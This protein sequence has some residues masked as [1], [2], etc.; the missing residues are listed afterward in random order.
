MKT[1]PIILFVYNRPWHTRQ[2]VEAL[3]KNKLADQSDLIIYADGAKNREAVPAVEEVRAYLKTITGFK[4]ISIIEQNENRGLANSIIE[5]VTSVVNQ[6]GRVIVVEDDLVTSSWFLGYMN[7]GLDIFQNRD[8]IFS[9]TGFNYPKHT[10]DI[11]SWYIED[12]Y[13]SYRCMSWTWGTWRDRWDKVD[14]DVKDFQILEKSKEKI[15]AFNRGGED[16]FPMLKSQMENKIDSWAIRFCYA[17]HI[18]KSYCV[19]PVNS[20]VD[21]TGF[22][23]SGVHCGKDKEKKLQNRFLNQSSLSLNKDIKIDT[24]ILENFYKITK[25]SFTQKIKT[26]VRRLI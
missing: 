15:R 4:S 18:H 21:N 5:G 16:L 11:P 17:H 25:K 9:I 3:Q 14:W 8:D 6:Y 26:F 13:L 12:I 7:E 20:F 1:A 23:G 22:D 24:Q 10:L 2:T 19:Y